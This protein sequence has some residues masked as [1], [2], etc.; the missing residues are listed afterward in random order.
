MADAKQYRKKC[1][2]P[3]AKGRKY[4]GCQSIQKYQGWKQTYITDI[5]AKLPKAKI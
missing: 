2:V 3:A 1:F 5:N 4:Q